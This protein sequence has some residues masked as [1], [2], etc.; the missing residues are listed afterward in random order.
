LL[1]IA[2]QGSP[3]EL[4]KVR[5][6]LDSTL[7]VIRARTAKLSAELS[8]GRRLELAAAQARAEQISSRQ[9]LVERRRQFA[10]LE[11]KAAELAARTGSQALGAGDAAIVAAETV[12]GLR[13]AEGSARSSAA[14]AAQLALDEPAPGRPFTPEGAAPGPPFAYVLPVAA[15]VTEG[16]ASV[17]ASGVQS[18]GLTFGTA[19]GAPVTAPAP[20]IVRYSGPFR[21]YDGVLIIDHG[22][23]W[24]SLIVNLSS[25]LKVGDRIQLGQPV[26]RALGPVEVEL[27]QFGR[28][29]SPALIAGSSQNLSKAPKGG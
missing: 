12:E 18:R 20:G 9:N 1:A 10:A 4:V 21:D 13:G 22:G 8:E 11:Q 16:L 2:D 25:E 19:R 6:L 14:L 26:G 15:P 7:P 3:D 24:M 17:N 23:G 28:R 27:S 5:V 29:I